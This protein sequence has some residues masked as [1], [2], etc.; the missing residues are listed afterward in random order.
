VHCYLDNEHAFE[1]KGLI[2]WVN[3]YYVLTPAGAA[4]VSALRG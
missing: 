1:R 3:H 4:L 2:R